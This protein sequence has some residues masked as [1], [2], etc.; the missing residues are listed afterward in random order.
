[1]IETETSWK[2]SG[3]DCDH[4]GGE[5][6]VRIDQETNQRTR[7]C[8]QCRQCGCQWSMNGN[9][10]RTGNMP[11]CALAQKSRM[12]NDWK[13]FLSSRWLMILVG[14]VLFLIVLRFAWFMFRLLIPLLVIALLIFLIIRLGKQQAWW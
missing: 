12:N 6:A 4:C 2:D 8:Y 10:L 1:M 13:R 3:Y 5:I 9:A 7:Q 11:E 14:T